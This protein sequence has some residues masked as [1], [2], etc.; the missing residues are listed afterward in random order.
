MYSCG[1]R[2]LWARPKFPSGS[3]Q[4]QKHAVVQ[5]SR[6]RGAQSDNVDR[7]RAP[8]RCFNRADL[9][10]SSNTRR[11]FDTQNITWTGI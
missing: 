1:N 8:G 11:T 5:H 7:S 2:L 4:E 9:T 3:A 6:A 10:Y